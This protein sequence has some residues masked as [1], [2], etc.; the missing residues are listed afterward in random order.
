[1]GPESYLDLK[2]TVLVTRQFPH[3][4]SNS[5]I[6]HKVQSNRSSKL[7]ARQKRGSVCHNMLYSQSVISSE[8]CKQSF[9]EANNNLPRT[10]LNY[11]K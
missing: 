6:L 3:E 2:Q 1:M 10:D 9:P 7:I 5:S 8:Y 11:L 4:I